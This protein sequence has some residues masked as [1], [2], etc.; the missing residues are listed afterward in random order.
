MGSLEEHNY[1]IGVDVGGTLG[2]VETIRA[3]TNRKQAPTLTRC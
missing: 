3:Q 1:R 2:M